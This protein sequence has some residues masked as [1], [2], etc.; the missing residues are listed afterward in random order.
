MKTEA[1]PRWRPEVVAFADAMERKLRANDY[2]GGWKDMAPHLLLMRVF[3][4]L[5]E[6][7]ETIRP[8]AKASVTFRIV[9]FL[10]RSAAGALAQWGPFM[11]TRANPDCLDEA[12]DVANLL[13]MVVDTLGKLPKPKRGAP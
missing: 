7:V 1:A 9:G 8:E 5:D 4:E 11:R 13:M 12:A 6:F 10:S 3:D 2:K